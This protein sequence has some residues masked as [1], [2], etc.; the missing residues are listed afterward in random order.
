MALF[1][2]VVRSRS[3]LW[4]D[5]MQSDQV[6]SFDMR[7]IC[8]DVL[9]YG[10]REGAGKVLGQYKSVVAVLCDICCSE[11][12]NEALRASLVFVVRVQG[13]HIRR[14]CGQVSHL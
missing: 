1:I 6:I 11:D 7:A 13:R 5:V 3:S 8:N 4:S 2:Q 10:L 9:D 14:C 12:G